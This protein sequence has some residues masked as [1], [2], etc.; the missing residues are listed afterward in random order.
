M[1]SPHH[2]SHVT[3]QA[4]HVT[5]Q[6]SRVRC[7]VSQVF[8]IVGAI[9]WRICYQPGLPRLVFKILC[10]AGAVLQTASYFI[11]LLSNC[12]TKESQKETKKT[13][14]IR[15]LSNPIQIVWDPFSAW[16]FFYS[17][18]W[19]LN[20]I[21]TLWDTFFLNLNCMIFFHLHLFLK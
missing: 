12:V 2:V 21:P 1:F 7:L 4:S 6:V 3:C 18:G 16:I 9:R 20:P 11:H 17:R 10:V 14:H 8:F 15:T 13:A 19:G 5:S